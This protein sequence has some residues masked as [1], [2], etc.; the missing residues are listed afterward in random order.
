MLLILCAQLLLIS[1]L[2]GTLRRHYN[3]CVEEIK[4][5]VN[6]M[7]GTKVELSTDKGGAL[8]NIVITATPNAQSTMVTL[9]L[10]TGAAVNPPKRSAMKEAIRKLKTLAMGLDNLEKRPASPLP[11]TDKN[12]KKE[13][14]LLPSTPVEPTALKKD[15]HYFSVRNEKPELVPEKQKLPSP[16]PVVPTPTKDEHYFSVRKE[17]VEVAVPEQKPQKEKLPPP[18]PLE[19]NTP[20]KDEHYFSV[21]KEKVEV[22]VPEQNPQKQALPPPTPLKPNTQKKEEDFFSLPKTKT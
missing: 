21:R 16:A 11:E 22:A 2:R 1:L 9:A 18:A 7:Y 6:Q 8:D 5:L 13:E 4:K 15:D 12:E 10:G 3:Q 17:K 20:K 14:K 19:P